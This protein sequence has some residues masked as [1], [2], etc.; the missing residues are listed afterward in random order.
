MIKDPLLASQHERVTMFLSLK[1]HPD[2]VIAFYT[3]AGLKPGKSLLARDD[4]IK[5]EFEAYVHT[6]RRGGRSIAG[7]PGDEIC[8]RFNEKNG[9]TAHSCEWEAVGVESNLFRPDLM[10]DFSTGHSL[11]PGGKPVES[12]LTDDAVLALWDKMSAGI[13]VRP[14]KAVRPPVAAPVVP[15]IGSGVSAYEACPASGWWQCYDGKPLGEVV[16]GDTQ[17]FRRGVRMPQAT[18][19]VPPTL[20]QRIKR[21]RPTFQHEAPTYWKLVRHDPPLPPVQPGIEEGEDTAGQTPKTAAADA[22]ATA[23]TATGKP[24]NDGNE[25]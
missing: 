7:I 5:Q 22:V 24:G 13:R 12:S 15:E 6:F 11:R 19:L 18:L 17:F 16:L 14:T 2:F 20:W 3:A 4:A 25:A 23:P 21:E 10:L 9:T 8:E 1:D